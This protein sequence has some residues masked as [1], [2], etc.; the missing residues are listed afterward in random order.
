MALYWI[1]PNSFEEVEALYNNTK[2]LGGSKNKG[3][4]IRPTGDRRRKMERVH[5]FTDNCYG[6]MDG[7][8]ADPM[9]WWAH[10]RAT[11]EQATET[12]MLRH[13]PIVWRRHKD[14]SQTVTIRNESG[15]GAHNSRYSFLDR[16]IP[17]AMRFSI[18]NGKHFIMHGGK[19]Y[20]LAKSMTFPAAYV[21]K[22]KADAEARGVEL[23]EWFR[24]LTARDDGV[25]LTFKR[26]NDGNFVLETG[27]KTLPKPPRTLVKK[28]QKAKYKKAIDDFWEWVVAMAPMMPVD[29]WS[30]R[31]EMHKELYVY[32]TPQHANR[33]W[34]S[35]REAIP[36]NIAIRIL[37]DYNNPMR[38]NLAVA[39][40]STS[41]I[42]IAATREDAKRV[43]AQYNRW[44]NKV[45]GFTVIK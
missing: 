6:L 33:T 40:V 37:T 39:F 18:R 4:D 14:G 15:Q 19:D 27:G 3:K 36:A 20:F 23:G 10:Y 38:L 28:A 22:V 11:E 41:D 30:Y 43:R 13:A 16:H 35:S 8:V 25:A 1:K 34:F 32:A 42:K 24:G 26:V 45:C 7:G 17:R 5:K 12:E 44:I 9:G 21:N 2:P 31:N 29:D